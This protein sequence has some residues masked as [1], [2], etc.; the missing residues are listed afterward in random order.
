MKTLLR[1]IFCNL[2]VIKH[3][4]RTRDTAAP[5][6]IRTWFLQKILGFNR[7]AYWPAHFTSVISR[8]NNIKIGI[9]TAPGLSPGCYIQ[10]SGSIEIGD[11]TIIGPNVGI[12]SSN[13]NILNHREYIRGKVK[14]GKY[15]WIGMNAVILPDVEL[16]DHTIVGASAVVTKSFPE[17]YCVLTGIPAKVLKTINK[18]D[19]I[20]V[21]NDY[22]YYGYIPKKKYEGKRKKLHIYN[23][24]VTKRYQ[25]QTR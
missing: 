24:E 14:I 23:H 15:C 11:Y 10:G 16:G 21:P 18:E 8:V 3:I 7:K 13:H 5:I 25:K 1:K 22:E 20:E 19:V 4:F 2:P 12:I 6:N 17:G 9:G